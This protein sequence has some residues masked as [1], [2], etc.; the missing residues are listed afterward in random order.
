MSGTSKET[1]NRSVMHKLTMSRLVNRDL[2]D[3]HL[4]MVEMTTMLPGSPTRIPR[5]RIKFETVNVVNDI[6]VVTFIL[7]YDPMAPFSSSLESFMNIVLH[8]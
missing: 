1:V 7:P 3:G 6:C 8:V 2:S 5:T 4:R